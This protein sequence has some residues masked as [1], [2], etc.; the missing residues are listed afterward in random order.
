MLLLVAWTRLVPLN[1]QEWRRTQLLVEL[2]GVLG[3]GALVVPWGTNG[4]VIEE[5]RFVARA[6]SEGV[7]W[8]TR[9]VNLVLG[10]SVSRSGSG[11]VMLA[12]ALGVYL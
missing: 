5:N 6:A 2:E 9:P 3:G 7:P 11:V 1:W 10:E 8:Y 12:V 4:A